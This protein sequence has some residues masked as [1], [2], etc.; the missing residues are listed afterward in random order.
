VETT[1]SK[2]ELRL[3]ARLGLGDEG[4]RHLIEAM[5]AGK[6]SRQAVV[7]S[8]LAPQ[9]YVPPFPCE[10]LQAP[11]L[12]PRVYVPA[13]GVK[14][15]A[16]EDYAQGLYYSLDLSSC[17]ESACLAV[18]P[19]PASSLDM[20]AAPGGKTMLMAARFGSQQH[21][22][23]EVHPG[24]RGI[25]R[26]NLEQCGM[27]HV[28]VTGNRPDQWARSGETFD[29]LLV[30]A[31]CSG[32]SLLCKGIK[33]PGCLSS[34]M[35]NGNAKRQK[36]IMLSAV[37]CVNPGGHIVY[38]TCTYDPEENEKVMAYILKRHPEWQAVEVPQ[39]APFRS[40]LVDFP[41]YRLLPG[42]GFGAGGFC[43]LLEKKS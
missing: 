29:L 41:A 15:T 28:R 34:S 31:P 8:P 11:W 26:Q 10:E 42:H 4:T 5:R 17:W 14:P 3:C 35:V 16:F 20:C 43:C 37:Q 6:S 39:L 32:Q 27:P 30:D 38:T 13:D 21:T 40:R 25:L 36:G 23:N 18:V 22:A 19:Q 33:N 1:A 24:R 9:D 12:P 2:A 7:L